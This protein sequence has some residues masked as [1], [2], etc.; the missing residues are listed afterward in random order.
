VTSHSIGKHKA[1]FFEVIGF[2][3]DKLE[4]LQQALIE[5]H[6]DIAYLVTA[7]PL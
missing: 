3:I 1:A 6:T 7:Y 5:N 4:V 2:R